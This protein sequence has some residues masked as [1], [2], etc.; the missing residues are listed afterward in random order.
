MVHSTNLRHL[1]VSRLRSMIAVT[2]VVAF[3]VLGDE[4][5]TEVEAVVRG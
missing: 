4:T 5:D 3:M 2:L 1:N